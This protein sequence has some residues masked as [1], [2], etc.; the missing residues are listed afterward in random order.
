MRR[1]DFLT[2]YRGTTKKKQKTYSFYVFFSYVCHLKV[3]NVTTRNMMKNG[4]GYL[5]KQKFQ[6]R[7]DY[8]GRTLLGDENFQDFFLF[9]AKLRFLRKIFISNYF[10]YRRTNLVPKSLM[11]AKARSCPRLRPQ[12][13]GTS[14]R[15][16][17]IPTHLWSGEA[18]VA[19][20]S[21]NSK[22]SLGIYKA[23]SQRFW[24]QGNK[25]ELKVYYMFQD[26]CTVYYLIQRRNCL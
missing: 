11:D 8:Q 9:V 2:D 15:S 26:R 14:L 20:W 18:W 17:M 13:L 6:T 12:D 25:D 19:L 16:Y 22:R 23:T 5:I 3:A 21:S 1:K 10:W 7:Y 24:W 4:K